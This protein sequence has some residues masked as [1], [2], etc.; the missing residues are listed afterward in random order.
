MKKQIKMIL[1]GMAI[2]LI[3][4]IIISIIC[5]YFHFGLIIRFGLSIIL[6]YL[7]GKNLAKKCF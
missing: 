7:L 5:E 6:G 1:L 4:S 3:G 2:L